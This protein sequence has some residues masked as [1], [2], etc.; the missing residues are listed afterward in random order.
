[1]EEKTV[2]RTEKQ[3]SENN[4]GRVYKVLAL[5]VISV[6][7]SVAMVVVGNPNAGI[8]AADNTQEKPA[9]STAY[10]IGVEDIFTVGG[11]TVLYSRGTLKMAY[12]DEEDQPDVDEET[13]RKLISWCRDNSKLTSI[14][15]AVQ[16]VFDKA[17]SE[18]NGTY[19]LT[20]PVKALLINGVESVDRL[21]LYAVV[22]SADEI[23]AK[24]V[25]IPYE[26]VTDTVSGNVSNVRLSLP[27]AKI[28][29]IIDN[30]SDGEEESDSEDETEKT[31]AE[32]KKPRETQSGQRREEST[33]EEYVDCSADENDEPKTK[34]AGREN[35]T[36]P[37]DVQEVMQAETLSDDSALAGVEENSPVTGGHDF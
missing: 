3:S 21:A 12:E 10:S 23:G 15:I 33:T 9:E 20:V 1:M 13:V 25:E 22:Q 11:A 24:L 17:E 36:K 4:R 26:P 19:S 6:I 37:A 27:S 8:T 35:V 18:D 2:K 29:L 32:A 16:T 34:P 7:L 14:A 28:L 5:A 30:K 31:T